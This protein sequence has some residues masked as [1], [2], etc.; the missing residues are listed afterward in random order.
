VKCYLVMRLSTNVVSISKDLA[1][2]LRDV[3]PESSCFHPLLDPV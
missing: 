2:L 3:I 1:T